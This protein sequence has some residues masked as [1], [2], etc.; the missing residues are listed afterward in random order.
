MKNITEI[1][2]AKD[3]SDTPGARYR[4]DGD[5]SGEDFFETLLHPRFNEAKKQG[6]LL[7]IDLDDVWGYPS[8]FISGSFGILSKQ[9]GYETVLAH[10]HFKSDEDPLLIDLIEGI[11]RNP[12]KE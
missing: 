3:F 12:D 8:S 11:I 7:L 6:G 10:I 1:S 4:K 2:I 5:F 9:Y